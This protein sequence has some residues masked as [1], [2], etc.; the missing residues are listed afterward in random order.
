MVQT[1]GTNK[2]MN[3]MVWGAFWDLERSGYYITD[4]DFDS[5]KHGYSA[6]LYLE[7]CDAEVAPTFEE[8]DDGYLFM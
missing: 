3:I 8:L 5:A 2:N 6:R 7:V 4:R 1:Y